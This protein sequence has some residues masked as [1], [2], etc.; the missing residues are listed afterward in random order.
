MSQLQ[1]WL[2]RGGQEL[3]SRVRRVAQLIAPLPHLV[4]LLQDPVHRPLRAEVALLVEQLGVD[5][6]RGEIDERELVQH[7]EHGR[8]FGGRERARRT[9]TRLRRGGGPIRR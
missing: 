4:I 7:L 2:G 1:T 9:R 5:L 6:R 3:G 8:A